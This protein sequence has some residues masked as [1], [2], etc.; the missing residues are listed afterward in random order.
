MEHIVQKR[1]EK[2]PPRSLSATWED[3]IKIDRKEIRWCVV[4][5]LHLSQN[6]EQ[7]CAISSLAERLSALQVD[8][9]L[10]CLLCLCLH[11]LGTLVCM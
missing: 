1:G 11:V 5:Y 7:R 9:A 3:N 10:W 4:E 8:S 6:R 2:G